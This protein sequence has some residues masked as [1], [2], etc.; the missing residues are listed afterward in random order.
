[1]I[2]PEYAKYA[3]V[4]SL[5][6]VPAELFVW[7]PEALEG[8][9]R[10]INTYLHD[11]NPGMQEAESAAG[12]YT[13]ATSGGEGD[14]FDQHW[15]AIAAGGDSGDLSTTAGWTAGL[16]SLG[17][18]AIKIAQTSV[19]TQLAWCAPQLAASVAAGPAGALNAA[20]A[21]ATARA[22]IGAIVR[23]LTDRL[24]RLIA[25]KLRQAGE[26]FRR[27]GRQFD[28]RAA[29]NGGHRLVPADGP[30][31]L[32]G[33]QMNMGDKNKGSSN[34]GAKQE[35]ETFSWLP[36]R[37][38]DEVDHKPGRTGDTC[39]YCGGT[40]NDPFKDSRTCPSCVGTGRNP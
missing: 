24:E 1:M 35:E 8:L 31:H 25:P 3:E 15:Q 33:R 17:A 14:A 12:Q 5:V 20:R 28:P 9:A 13:A 7:D 40:G 4:A 27:L 16:L 23:K 36:R 32:P 10:T 29:L 37:N 26:L 6:G 2:H 38:S 11:A 30:I 34:D 21:I 22:T 39:N 18:I 19:V